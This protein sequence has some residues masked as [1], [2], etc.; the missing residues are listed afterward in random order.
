M[1]RLTA[2]SVDTSNI[3]GEASQTGKALV[4]SNVSVDG[5]ITSVFFSGLFRFKL[6]DSRHFQWSIY[7]VFDEESDFQVKNSQILEPGGKK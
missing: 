5:K 3:P 1:Q 7:T 6:E 2:W 4:A